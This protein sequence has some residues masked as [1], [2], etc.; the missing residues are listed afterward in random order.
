MIYM[1]WSS[2]AR[3][4]IKRRLRDSWAMANATQEALSSSPPLK[5]LQKG[6]PW[7]IGPGAQGGLPRG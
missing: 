4:T 7:I 2:T 1:G 6:A 5:Y 3:I